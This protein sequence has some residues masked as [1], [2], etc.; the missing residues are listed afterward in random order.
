MDELSFKIHLHNNI[1]D[2]WSTLTASNF[3][4]FLYPLNQTARLVSTE[5]AAELY[6]E[7]DAMKILMIPLLHAGDNI[8]SVPEPEKQNADLYLF[9][10]PNLK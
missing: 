5:S 6:D 2:A 8:I 7:E 9:E 4:Y 1:Q 10:V 3:Y